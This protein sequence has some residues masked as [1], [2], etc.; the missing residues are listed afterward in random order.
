MENEVA[1]FRDMPLEQKLRFSRSLCREAAIVI[2]S[3]ADASRIWAWV[4]PL[5]ES[6]IAA[7]ERLGIRGP[8]MPS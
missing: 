4:D 2:A 7:F 6:T 1:E 5:P 8:G 3:R